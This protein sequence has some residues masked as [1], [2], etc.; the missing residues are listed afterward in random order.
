MEIRQAL[1]VLGLGTKCSADEA[2]K[3]YRKLAKQWHPDSKF[4]NSD[5]FVK[6]NEAYQEVVKFIDLRDKGIGELE[7][8]ELGKKKENAEKLLLRLTIENLA[9]LK[10]GR[11]LEFTGN[12]GQKINM[13]WADLEKHKI[14]IQD[15]VKI[16]DIT[17]EKSSETETQNLT[18]FGTLD[19]SFGIVEYKPIEVRLK[20]ESRSLKLAVKMD[21][22]EKILTTSADVLMLSFVFGELI[23]KVKLEIKRGSN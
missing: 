2:K 9:V 20:N 22:S 17:D 16:T 18:I 19:K 21:S 5:K 7:Y 3:Q 13:A 8:G 4:G 6:I 12:R 10:S 14:I 1:E 11:Q 23:A 15:N